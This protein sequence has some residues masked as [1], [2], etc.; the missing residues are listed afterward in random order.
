M[1]DED[2][3]EES[4]TVEPVEPE[5]EEDAAELIQRARRLD[6]LGLVSLAASV[7]L[8]IRSRARA[9]ALGGA[10]AEAR[11]NESLAFAPWR[12]T[13]TPEEPAKGGSKGK[14]KGKGKGRSRGQNGRR[15][16]Y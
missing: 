15:G 11:V 2:S 8:E 3:E 4:V 1:A 12:R 7:V 6:W 9:E 13:A 5:P 16:P 14:S 10:L